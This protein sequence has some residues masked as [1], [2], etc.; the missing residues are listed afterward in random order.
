MFTCKSIESFDHLSIVSYK[1]YSGKD[2]GKINWKI[3]VLFIPELVK[4][5]NPLGLLGCLNL[6][7]YVYVIV[8]HVNIKVIS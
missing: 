3:R 2:N 6:G 4:M 8:V 7:V 1:K 5:N